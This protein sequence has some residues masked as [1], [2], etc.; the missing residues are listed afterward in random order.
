MFKYLRSFIC[1]LFL[2]TILSGLNTIPALSQYGEFNQYVQAQGWSGNVAFNVPQSSTALPLIIALHPAQTPETAM[3]Q[4]MNGAANQINAILACPSG[5][6]GDGSAIMPLIAWCKAN[7]KVD[8]TKI[9]LTGYSAGSWPTF[10]TG[11]PN[12][13]TFRGLIGIAGANTQGMTQEAVNGVGIGLICGTGDQNYSVMKSF[14]TQ[15]KN[16]KGYI[17]FHEKSG[18]GHTGQYFW[19]SEF[20]ADWVDLYNFCINI[21]FKPN[22]ISLTNPSNGEENLDFTLTLEWE[23]DANASS[24]E[25]EI[26]DDNG[27]IESK[28]RNTN[29]YVLKN[30]KPGTTYYW[31]VMGKNSA[32]DGPWSYEWRFTTKPIAPTAQVTLLEP[33]DDA[34]DL[35][36]D[37]YFRWNEIE[38]ASEYHIQILDENDSIFKEYPNVEPEE[39][40]YV[41]KYIRNLESNTTY[42]WQVRG[43]NSAGEGPW[44]EQRTFTTAPERPSTQVE[45]SEPPDNETDVS[46]LTTLK[47][48]T[49]EGATQYYLQMKIFGEDD[50]IVNDSAISAP[51]QG[52]EV[53]YTFDKELEG[54]TKYQWRVCGL[55]SGG[56][57]PWSDYRYFTTWDPT[58]VNESIN[59][60]I[61]LYPNPSS[62]KV[63]IEFELNEAML[64]NIEI[65]DVLGQKVKNLES[66]N[67]NF[68]KNILTLDISDLAF[69]NYILNINIGNKSINKGLIVIP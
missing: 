32:G 56:K 39:D 50:F 52:I 1:S 49:I 2:L 6:D 62:D 22:R 43:T 28:V 44:S 7:Y 46:T 11:F 9:F 23:E 42:K 45:L 30:L 69:G 35:E 20:T 51:E 58:G 61:N 29:N 26:S 27:I 12:F 63:I 21:V 53:V 18:V 5:P 16:M 55:N 33:E 25:V 65:F 13:K 17:K 60:E 66:N 41:E 36:T 47:W 19:S 57:G 4:M 54:L 15:V 14:E 10:S 31:K 24:Y 3:R 8:D 59:N 64:V 48:K 40:E 34:K 68:G 38:Q 37:I 67:L